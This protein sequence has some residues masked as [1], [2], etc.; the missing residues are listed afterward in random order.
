MC[1]SVFHLAL[2]AL[3]AM[4]RLGAASTSPSRGSII[5]VFNAQ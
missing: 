2:V 4:I 3:F 5:D 1:R